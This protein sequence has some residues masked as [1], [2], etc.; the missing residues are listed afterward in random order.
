MNFKL[1]E[2]DK[3]KKAI[4]NHYDTKSSSAEINMHI[5]SM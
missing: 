2:F 4:T 1:D 3:A 5:D